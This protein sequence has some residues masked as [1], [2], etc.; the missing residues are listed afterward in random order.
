MIEKLSYKHTLTPATTYNNKEH[1]MDTE[2]EQLES[3]QPQYGQALP[4][5]F[6]QFYVLHN[7][8]FPRSDFNTP[9]AINL[10]DYELVALVECSHKEDA[11]RATNHIEEDWTKNPEVKKLF[12]PTARSTSVSDILIDE[13]GWIWYCAA[14][15][16]AKMG[17]AKEIS[18]WKILHER[19]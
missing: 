6:Y 2:T 7:K 16:W 9:T 3:L 18:Y 19:Q 12:T 15:G 14:T 11:F 17:N 13:D 1:T 8:K 10:S 5:V 4:K